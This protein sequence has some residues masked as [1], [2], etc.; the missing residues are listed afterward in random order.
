MAFTHNDFG[1]LVSTDPAAAHK[2]LKELF[3]FHAGST[4]VISTQLSCN[5]VTLRRWIKKLASLGFADPGDGDRR[6]RGASVKRDLR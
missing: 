1:R 2:R 5:V 6:G 3:R 4:A